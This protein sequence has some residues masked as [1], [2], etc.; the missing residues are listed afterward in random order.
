M[1]LVSLTLNTTFWA[2]PRQVGSNG[3]AAQRARSLRAPVFIR[4]FWQEKNWEKRWPKIRDRGFSCACFVV[5]FLEEFWVLI[6][7][8]M[9]QVGA[10]GTEVRGRFYAIV[11]ERGLCWFSSINIYPKL[12]YPPTNPSS[13]ISVH[14]QNPYC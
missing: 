7:I 9:A 5:E 2:V 6:K 4:R 11:S 1:A 12:H 8:E 3:V 13:R 10:G 14:M